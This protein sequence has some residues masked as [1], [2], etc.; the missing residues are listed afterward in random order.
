MQ[1]LLISIPIPISI[2]N[3]A[4]FIYPF[5]FR[6]SGGRLHLIQDV[7]KIPL[8]DA[9]L[10]EEPADSD[11]EDDMEADTLSQRIYRSSLSV[12]ETC[13]GGNRD[14]KILIESKTIA[15]NCVHLVAP[16]AQDKEAWISDISQCIDNIHLHSMLSPS[17]DRA[18]VGGLLLHEYCT[19]CV[20]VC[21]MCFV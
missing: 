7:G 1:I 13:T 6:T 16:T 5:V 9:T 15:R 19:C 10:I 14:F 20:C 4:A 17:D 18:S 8:A 2:F 3:F 11:R 21:V 12:N